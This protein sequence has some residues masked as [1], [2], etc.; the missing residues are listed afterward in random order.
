MVAIV[1]LVFASIA[2]LLPLINAFPATV[3]TNPHSAHGHQRQGD[4]SVKFQKGFIPENLLIFGDSYTDS[5]NTARYNDN[6]TA[7]TVP[8]PT[9]YPLPE[10]RAAKGPTWPEHFRQLQG[11]KQTKHSPPGGDPV[12]GSKDQ[13]KVV[14][15]AFSA[16]TCN[17]DLFPR[18][19]PD[20]GDQL[21]LA[22]D[23]FNGTL[24]SGFGSRSVAKKP[25]DRDVA[26]IWIGTNDLNFFTV[27]TTT[28]RT[29]NALDL[30]TDPFRAGSILDYIDCIFTRFDKL[31]QL[32]YRKFVLF[33]LT[34]L[35]LTPAYNP[36]RSVNQQNDVVPFG[37]PTVIQ[38]LTL[39]ANAIFPY[40]VAAFEQKYQ[41]AKMEIFPTHDLFTRLYFNK[42]EYGFTDVQTFC[43][44]CT[45]A[46]RGDLWADDLHFSSQAAKIIAAKLIRFFKGDRGDNL[47]KGRD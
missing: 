29:E 17:N 24:Q 44:N 13:T 1:S 19:V 3:E 25:T 5:C 31:Y 35:E 34:P 38:Q 33:E 6:K 8:F 30:K 43:Q 42:E 11:Q 47:L 16:A 26:L 40:K 36:V 28:N 46:P 2:S 10:G 14:N 27:N 20:V 39:S 7:D 18:T 37:K 21:K 9:C 23:G 12:P 4:D 22:Q 41:D 15:L 32:G 45:F